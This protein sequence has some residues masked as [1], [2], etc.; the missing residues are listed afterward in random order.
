MPQTQANQH[1]PPLKV[2]RTTQRPKVTQAAFARD[3]F[4]TP[5]TVA[6]W[7]RGEMNPHKKNW[8]AVQRRTGMTPR[9]FLHVNEQQNLAAD[10]TT[11]HDGGSSA[12]PKSDNQQSPLQSDQQKADA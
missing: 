2:W 7:D 3:V 12:H 10:N 4:V 11:G 9:Q 5:D 1:L 8:A 6:R